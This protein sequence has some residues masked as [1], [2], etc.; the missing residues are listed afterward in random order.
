VSKLDAGAAVGA[1]V[2]VPIEP[3]AGPLRDPR[4]CSVDKTAYLLNRDYLM[5]DGWA[6]SQS[7]TAHNPEGAPKRQGWLFDAGASTWNSG[8]GTSPV[9]CLTHVALRTI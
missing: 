7:G 9:S 8:F 3:L 4:V 6:A 1:V 5:F 2:H